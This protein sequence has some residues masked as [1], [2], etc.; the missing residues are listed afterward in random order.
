MK[1]T[2]KKPAEKSRIA[3]FLTTRGWTMTSGTNVWMD[4]RFK[5]VPG[6]LTILRGQKDWYFTFDNGGDGP[7][8]HGYDSLMQ[9]INRLEALRGQTKA[10]HASAPTTAINNAAKGVPGD[11]PFAEDDPFADRTATNH[12][13][14]AE[15]SDVERVIKYMQETG[16]VLPQQVASAF[17]WSHEE[18]FGV[19]QMLKAENRVGIKQMRYYV[20]TSRLRMQS[21]LF[22]NQRS[23]LLSPFQLPQNEKEAGPGGAGISQRSLG[24]YPRMRRTR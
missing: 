14:N 12:H 18:A 2:A 3:E 22:Y 24:D 1:H 6:D 20:K 11:D 13:G 19:L 5:G 15:V 8:G 9:S 17:G 21:K 4:F 23:R 16:A 10:Q 7:E